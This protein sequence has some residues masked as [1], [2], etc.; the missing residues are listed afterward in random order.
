MQFG[1]EIRSIGEHK[2]R[3]IYT[4]T[5]QASADLQEQHIANFEFLAMPTVDYNTCF[6][7]LFFDETADCVQI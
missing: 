5:V 6:R 3:A 7:A 2:S 4:C 1:E